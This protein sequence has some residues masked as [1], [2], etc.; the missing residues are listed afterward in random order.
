MAIGKTNSC[1][2]AGASLKVHGIA[3]DTLTVTNGSRT[4][5]R[6]FD[7]DGIAVIKG[8]AAGTWTETMTGSGPRP[9]ENTITIKIAYEDTL[10]Y[11]QA[12]IR[13]ECPVESHLTCA[14][15]DGTRWEADA[16]TGAYEFKVNKIGDYTITGTKDGLSDSHIVSITMDGQSKSVSISYFRA[17]INVNYPVGSICYA[18]CGDIRLTA[19]DQDGTWQFAIPKEGEWHIVCSLE[20]KSKDAYVNITTDGQEETVTLVYALVLFDDGEWHPMTGGFTGD[21]SNGRLS[22]TAAAYGAGTDWVS[23]SASAV[24]KGLIDVTDYKTCVFI[25]VSFNE[26]SYTYG[27]TGAELY[28]GT[29]SGYKTGS[30]VLDISEISG[31]VEIGM[32][33]HVSGPDPLNATVSCSKIYLE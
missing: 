19:G 16:P 26:S 21:I 10:D 7:E 14:H 25:G 4:Y 11:F 29:A 3:G 12:T 22:C 31:K 9:A 13:V 6:V 18:A 33:V 8:I 30:L 32:S 28:C 15:T 2:G 20:D 27:S 24:A 5:T 23:A 17:Y 1:G